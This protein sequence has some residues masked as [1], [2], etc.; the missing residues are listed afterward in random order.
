MGV[1][2]REALRVI[3][4]ESIAVVHR[5]VQDTVRVPVVV[6]IEAVVTKS[7]KA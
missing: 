4:E 3:A 2:K 6:H 7:V 1:Q 5:S